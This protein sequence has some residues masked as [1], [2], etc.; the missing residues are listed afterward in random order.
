MIR[1]EKSPLCVSLSELQAYARAETGEEEA[2]L[3]GLLRVASE[4]CETFLN[5][6]LLLRS[7]E[8]DITAG[9]GWT[10]LGV[11]PVRSVSSIFVRGSDEVLP[12]GE[13][14]VDIDH[15]GKAFIKGLRA[16]TVFT[17]RGTA[18][19]GDQSNAIPEPIRQGILRLAAHLF[20]NRDSN[21][22]MLPAVV[23]AL[24]RPFR[25][26]GLCR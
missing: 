11:Q 4:T 20:T 5:Q 12:K 7:F 8:Q 16:G 2:V 17:V 6:A 15:D 18:G 13:Y 1:Q 10:L 26:A 22:G 3:A 9:E 21:N 19:L 25:R 14:Q 24:W 23:T